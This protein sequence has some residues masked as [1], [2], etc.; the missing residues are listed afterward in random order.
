MQTGAGGILDA[1]LDF[2]AFDFFNG[3]AVVVAVVG[4]RFV[5]F[6]GFFLIVSFAVAFD[7]VFA[8]FFFVF[9]LT[10]LRGAARDEDD[11]GS[12]GGVATDAVLFSPLQRKH[13][14]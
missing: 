13:S 6:L 4:F 8:V 12:G 2:V 5:V 10:R 9:F 11:V 3:L 14:N 7:M 1:L